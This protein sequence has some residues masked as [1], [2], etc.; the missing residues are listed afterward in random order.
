M[1]EKV[2]VGEV[3][4]E[5]GTKKLGF[6]KVAE[7]ASMPVK[8]PVF[9]VNGS[10]TGPK[11]WVQGGIHGDE[12]EGPQ[13]IIRLARKMDPDKLNGTLIAVPVVNTLAFE[14]C[15]RTSP[16][17]N[18]DMNRV[19]PGK[20]DGFISEQVAYN[21]FNEIKA[22]ADFL[23]DLHSGGS[24]IIQRT[25]SIYCEVGS[26]EKDKTSKEMAEAF[27][28]SG[29]LLIGMKGMYLKGTCAIEA[30]KVGIPA[31]VG[32]AGGEGKVREDLVHA[33]YTG[34]LNL[35]RHLKMIPGDPIRLEKF[36][37][38]G[39][40]YFVRA[41]QGGYLQPQVGIDEKV[42]KGSLIAKIT[43]LFGEEVE[44][45]CSPMDGI[46]VGI[47]TLPAVNTGDRVILIAGL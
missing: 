4:A 33:H 5:P 44:A 15:Q 14:A 11:L 25:L 16:V 17:D 31:I 35:M 10:T 29:Q 41:T 39:E 30:S 13:A 9:V 38:A 43:N 37:Y 3:T 20:A 28:I 7:K 42:T 36:K 8:L 40:T 19:M 1:S 27:A 23:V 47:R 12:H 18:I 22:N 26:G 21:I 2:T 46:V 45:I 34:L 24:D 32:E 6:I